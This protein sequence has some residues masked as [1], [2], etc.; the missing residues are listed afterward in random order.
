MG[1]ITDGILLKQEYRR[2]NLLHPFAMTRGRDYDP[3]WKREPHHTL[4]VATEP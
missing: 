4:S 3:E 1:H 2:N